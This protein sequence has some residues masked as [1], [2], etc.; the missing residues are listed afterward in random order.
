MQHVIWVSESSGDTPY[1]APLSPENAKYLKRACEHLEP[2]SDEQYLN[3]PA[4]ILGTLA[5]SSYV[6][7]GDDVLWCAEWDPGLL[8]FQFSPS[9]SMARVALRSPVPHFGGREAT[10]E[11]H[12]AYNEDEPNPQYSVVFDAWD[13][14]FEDDTRQ[15][16]GFSPADDETVARFEAALAHVNSL[17]QRLGDLGDAWMESAKV[18]VDT[19]AGEGL[20]LA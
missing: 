4:A 13:A 10:D 8:V 11:E 2:M 5:R 1:S 18:N 16:K 3:G 7:A 9:G 17:G 15:W 20:R 14:Q 12:A 6:L 19:W